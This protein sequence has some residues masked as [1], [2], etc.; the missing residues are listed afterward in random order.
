MQACNMARCAS[1]CDLCMV[2]ALNTRHVFIV[3]SCSSCS[4]FTFQLDVLS[5]LLL[6]DL[7]R[8]GFHTDAHAL[9]RRTQH[10]YIRHAQDDMTYVQ[11]AYQHQNYTKCVEFAAFKQR[12]D[13]SM[14]VAVTRVEVGY[15]SVLVMDKEITAV[16]QMLTQ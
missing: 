5:H 6:D 12:L 7:L 8:Y 3:V 4:C 1:R 15:G 9:A 10:Y 2:I 11:L 14:Q 16:Q 13:R